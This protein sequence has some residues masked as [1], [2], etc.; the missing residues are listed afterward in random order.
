MRRLGMVVAMGAL[1]VWATWPLATCLSECLVD[2]A[3]QPRAVAPAVRPDI[4]LTLWILAWTT[5]A[6]GTDPTRLFDANVFHP[7]PRSLTTTEHM[8][9]A[10]PVYLPIAW[11]AGDPVAAH[12]GTL[13][14]TFVLSGLALAVLVEAWTGS[15]AAAFA[16]GAGFALSPFRLDHAGILPMTGVQYLPLV[17]LAAE[18]T[19]SRAAPGRWAAALALFLIVQALHSY[20]LA[21]ASFVMTGVLLAVVLMADA[22][23]RARAAWL[24]GA[25][26]AAAG[27]VAAVS[28]PYFVAHG[29]GGEAPSP[30]FVQAAS[31][32]P[33]RT[34]AT[35]MA[36]LALAAVPLW[37]RGTRGRVAGVWLAALAGVALVCHLLALGPTIALAGLT[38]PG[39]YALAAA[40]VP[41]WSMVRAPVRLSAPVVMGACA[42]AGVALAGAFELTGRRRRAASAA[43]VVL[44][45]VLAGVTVRRPLVAPTAETPAMIPPVYRWLGS[46]SPGAI[47][48]IPFHP[49]QRADPAGRAV[50]ARRT[51]RSVV[52]WQPMLGGYGGY[53]PPTY[54]AVGALVE[55]LPDP[56]A[57]ELL[58][59]LSGLRRIVVH[60]AELDADR[61]AAWDAAAA[62]AQVA[63][64]GDD[65][66]LELLGAPAPDLMDA[67]LS[68]G[69]TTPL[70][71]PRA[72][73]AERDRRALLALE[74][75][76]ARVPRLRPVALAVRVRNVGTAPWP[77][78][79]AT[80]RGLVTVAVR[81]TD[82]AGRS[83]ETTD[84]GRLPWDLPPGA[85]AVAHATIPPPRDALPVRFEI[86][87]AQDGRW[88][89]G[90]L[91]LSADA[92]GAVRACD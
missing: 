14:A 80:R 62:Y 23:A 40:V 73:L 5:H 92:S 76:L 65:R 50:E 29:G 72:A 8:L 26:A 20:Y 84:A 34:G 45:L 28:I 32:R 66:V 79:G 82:A 15:W 51:Y 21:Y 27:V 68:D 90:T 3:S 77:A 35:G 42:L 59:R 47:V 37:Q 85:E 52:H 10:L 43:V 63:R 48:E 87:L 54:A 64:L 86:G 16:A 91:A 88:F 67:F 2:A 53:A 6:L 78:V 7:A 1:A 49:F 9:G 13:L 55:A 71:T 75:P 31:A 89:D 74:A 11:A 4:D 61:R 58:A 70:G 36:L 56:R 17:V 41:G 83:R 57:A 60:D 39:P 25:Y 12:Q 44:A 81:W 33:G 18:R 38:L 69:E 19:V 46:A 30:A 22:R 24:A